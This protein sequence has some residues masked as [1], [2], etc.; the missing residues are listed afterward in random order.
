MHSLCD[1]TFSCFERTQACDRQTEEHR[2]IAYTALVQHFVV[3][4]A[5]LANNGLLGIWPLHWY[6]CILLVTLHC[7]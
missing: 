3:K 4:E 6:L 1:D 5:Q 2:A 7:Y